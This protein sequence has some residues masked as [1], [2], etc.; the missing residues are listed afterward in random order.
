MRESVTII[1]RATRWPNSWFPNA[2]LAD[3]KAKRL[4]LTKEEVFTFLTLHLWGCEDGEVWVN[5]SDLA[6]ELEVTKQTL[7]LHLAKLE[8]LGWI[9]R[10]V[11]AP[12]GKFDYPRHVIKVLE[13]KRG[14]GSIRPHDTH[15]TPGG[16]GSI[17][18]PGGRMN[19]HPKEQ[20][21][22]EAKSSEKIAHP[23]GALSS[24]QSEQIDPE[25]ARDG[26]EA[27]KTENQEEGES[28]LPEPGE[29]DAETRALAHARAR[30]RENGL[31][32]GPTTGRPDIPKAKEAPG[33][34]GKRRHEMLWPPEDG[35][36]VY[37]RWVEEMQ[38]HRPEFS[39][40]DPGFG[41]RKTRSGSNLKTAFPD[42]DAL[43]VIMRVA[44][45]DWRAIRGSIEGWYTKDKPIPTP[46]VI[47]KI[48]EQLAAK[49]SGYVT[50]KHPCSAYKAKFIDPPPVDYTDENGYSLAE[51]AR[52]ARGGVARI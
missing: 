37:L 4:D 6:S 46:E 14:S 23:S 16:G 3:W 41:T 32:A 20:E 40:P 48:A 7:R 49:P 33:K 17:R 13:E 28:T 43:L 47:Y 52:L 15:V 45:W 38:L 11:L 24:E 31:S 21:G 34:N 2:I 10:Y 29:D 42:P 27:V 39:A 51:Q 25:E 18:H 8:K 9:E 12:D 1:V 19:P 36:D 5:R 26:G 22:E 30:K 44:I 50:G 35:R